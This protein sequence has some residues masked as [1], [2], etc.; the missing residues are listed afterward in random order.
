MWITPPGD[1]S[2][3]LLC[4]WLD[5]QLTFGPA[6]FNLLGNKCF[7]SGCLQLIWTA[8]LIWVGGKGIRM[9]TAGACSRG[10]ELH[11]CSGSDSE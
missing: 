4:R 2:N 3:P 1:D 7:R 10:G 5:W 11:Y 8:C 9:I 6:L